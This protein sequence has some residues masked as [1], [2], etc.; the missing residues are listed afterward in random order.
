[1][2]QRFQ[3]LLQGILAV[4]VLLF[5][6]VVHGSTLL[7]SLFIHLKKNLSPRSSS[8]RS[9]D[10]G[11]SK[12]HG[13]QSTGDIAQADFHSWSSSKNGIPQ[14]LGL[15]FVPAARGQVSM[16]WRKSRAFQAPTIDYRPWDP[17]VILQGMLDD[18][19][20]LVR[21]SME[22]GVEEVLMYD[23]KGE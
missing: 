4:L 21:W 15:I 8:K 20:R 18:A 5:L 6:H 7:L 3:S 13:L 16:S 14:T 22:L 10:P 17:E 12:Q 23:E 2:I 19:G 9:G 11:R 1:M